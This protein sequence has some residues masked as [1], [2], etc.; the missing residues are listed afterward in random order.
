MA[1]HSSKALQ[2]HPDAA[3][4]HRLFLIG[5]VVHGDTDS[6]VKANQVVEKA[7]NMDGRIRSNNNMGK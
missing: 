2:L 7:H 5:Y 4:S 1:D 3:T 6:S